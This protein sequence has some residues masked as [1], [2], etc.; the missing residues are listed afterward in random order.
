MSSENLVDP[1]TFLTNQHHY[2]IDDI[3]ASA[4]SLNYGAFHPDQHNQE[5]YTPAALQV[6]RPK[7]AHPRLTHTRYVLLLVKPN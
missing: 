2:T 6:E 1:L 5:N 4:N 7:S 3:K